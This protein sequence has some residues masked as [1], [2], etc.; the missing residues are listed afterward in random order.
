ML[1]SLV[2]SEMCIRDR[3]TAWESAQAWIDVGR[4]S[5]YIFTQYSATQAIEVGRKYEVKVIAYNIIGDGPE[6]AY[7]EVI[8]LTNIPAIP[9]FKLQAHD[10][11][12]RL[13]LTK[14]D[15]PLGLRLPTYAYLIEEWNAV[16]TV[17]VPDADGSQII[18]SDPFGAAGTHRIISET[19]S[20]I[21]ID[22]LRMRLA[23][24]T[25][26]CLL[27]TSPSPRDS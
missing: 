24:H 1:R 14:V 23:G 19:D 21:V 13:M 4:S 3:D 6:S 10:A 25:I 7:K 18:T 5:S 12:I 8:P 11:A 27:Y 15:D 26:H 2:G 17:W 22:V 20:Q 16:D 9:P